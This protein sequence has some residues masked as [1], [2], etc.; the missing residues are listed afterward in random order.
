MAVPNT[1]RHVRRFGSAALLGALALASTAMRSGAVGQAPAALGEPFAD[2]PAAPA[3][4]WPARR[5]RNVLVAEEGV[6]ERAL[7][8]GVLSQRR[9]RAL[10]LR[11]G[12]GGPIAPERWP[13][14]PQS[15]S[16]AEPM[17]FRRALAELC[18]TALPTFATHAL[19][20]AV[21]DAAHRFEVDPFVLGALAHHQSA[22]GS[23][24]PDSWGVGVTRLNSGLWQPQLRAGRYRYRVPQPDGSLRSAELHVSLQPFSP[25]ALRDPFVNLHFSAALLRAFGEQCPAIDAPFR[26]APHRHPVSHLIWGDRVRSPIAEAQILTVRRRLLRYYGLPGPRPRARYGRTELDSPLDGAPRV[27]IGR[28]GEPRAGGRRVH[29]GIDLHAA[30]GEPVRAMADGRVGFAGAD[31]GP[32]GLRA[33]TPEQARE[34]PPGRMSAR[35]LFVRI[36][37]ADGVATLYAHLAS[38]LVQNGEAVRRGQLIGHVGRTGVHSSDAHLHLGLFDGD[39]VV[40]PMAHLHPLVVAPDPGAPADFTQLHPP[41]RR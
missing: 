33:L 10:G 21:L 24:A 39:A 16:F 2:E 18:G 14:E 4:P 5:R 23:A 28:M 13:P 30:M 22:C 9:L 26:S 7:E 1:A 29:A 19:A 37:H 38:Y 8:P 31:L 34:V 40:D 25:R 3:G 15:P 35:G 17:R 12:K 36:E 11:G 41:A 27:V 20:D 6:A 32:R